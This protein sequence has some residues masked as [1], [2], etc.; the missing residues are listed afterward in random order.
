M[1]N[2]GPLSPPQAGQ[3][4]RQGVGIL[5]YEAGGQVLLTQASSSQAS[6]RHFC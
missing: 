1:S 4:G 2:R 3:R 5:Q 6:K